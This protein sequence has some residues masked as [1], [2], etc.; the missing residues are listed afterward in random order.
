MFLFYVFASK[1]LKKQF[2]VIIWNVQQSINHLFKQQI[3]IRN[4]V[5]S[6]LFDILFILVLRFLIFI[7]Y[8]LEVIP[9]LLCLVNY[10]DHIFV[11]NF[12]M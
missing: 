11:W 12:S 2:N 1:I 7:L 3:D 10:F 4:D 8:I 5:F 6:I 9:C